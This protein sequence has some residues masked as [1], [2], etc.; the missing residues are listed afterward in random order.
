MVNEMDQGGQI[1]MATAEFEW[2]NFPEETT[3]QVKEAII[4]QGIES[5]P[6]ERLIRESVRAELDER[7]SQEK[8]GDDLETVVKECLEDEYIETI[9]EDINL[10][11]KGDNAITPN[12][13]DP[14]ARSDLTGIAL[15]TAI[16][17]G[18]LLVAGIYSTSTDV[19]NPLLA[20][21]GAVP[22]TIVLIAS[23]VFYI[24]LKIRGE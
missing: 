24:Q 7:L 8:G 14:P 4:K 21:L 12:N 13:V 19:I 1:H 3:N 18:S 11:D 17:S 6:I 9:T 15:A 5:A 2:E 23:I 10:H 16:A 20:S 22:L